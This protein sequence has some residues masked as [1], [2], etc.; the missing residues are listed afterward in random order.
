MGRG[1]GMSVHRVIVSFG[2][3]L[4]CS[5]RSMTKTFNAGRMACATPKIEVGAWHSQAPVYSIHANCMRLEQ[6]QLCFLMLDE[7][8]PAY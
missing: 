7:P 6:R 5:S 1:I 2:K 4:A 8:T 3:T